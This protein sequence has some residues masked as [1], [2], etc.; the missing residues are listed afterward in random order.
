MGGM[1]KRGNPRYPLLGS[2]SKALILNCVEGGKWGKTERI[3]IGKMRNQKDEKTHKKRN[4]TGH[5]W[6][7]FETKEKWSKS[8]V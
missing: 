1:K 7:G 5:K 2:F 3:R 4:R 6:D 8:G